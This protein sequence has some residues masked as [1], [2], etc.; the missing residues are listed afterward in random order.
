M[1]IIERKV[2]NQAQIFEAEP[3]ICKLG[4]IGFTNLYILAK[5]YYHIKI[6]IYNTTGNIIKISE[7]TIIEYL[8]TEVEDQSPNHISDFLQLYGYVDITLQAIYRR[9][10]YYLLQSKQLEQINLGNL[11]LLQHIKM[12]L[13]KFTDIFASENKFS[14]T[15]II[16]HQIK[17]RDVMPIKQR[18]YR[19]LPASHKII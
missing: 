11:D 19:I 14:R 17:T 12:L 8:T 6:P 13:N 10:K 3:T 16:Q 18:A 2:K 5:N 1:V 9:N 15:D 4:E 7:E